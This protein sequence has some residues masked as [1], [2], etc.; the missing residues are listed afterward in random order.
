MSI[1]RPDF[2][3]QWAT[4]NVIDPISGQNNVVTPP[5]EKQLNGWDLK[6]YPVRQWFNWLGRYTYLWIDYLDSLA[7]Q[8]IVNDGTEP[9]F[10]MVN[11][12]MAILYVTGVTNPT[13]FFNGML[14][15]PPQSSLPSYPLAFNK[16]AGD[17]ITGV[18]VSATGVIT[19][20]GGTGDFVCYGQMK[21]I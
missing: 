15:I 10:D 13:Q 6:E 14:Y 20:T 4:E 11:G 12:G 5:T 1:T 16:I 3:P 9:L 8:S 21:T 19:I 17:T 7:A 2:K 18:T